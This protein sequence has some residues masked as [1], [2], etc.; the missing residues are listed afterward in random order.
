MK[1][2][3]GKKV[4][5]LIEGA[6]SLEATVVSDSKNIVF[7]RIGDDEHVTRIV[8]NKIS[9]FKPLDLEDEK[10]PTLLMLFCENPTINCPGVKFIKKGDGFSQSDFDTFM[11][12]CK[13]RC[14]SCRRGSHGDIRC[15]DGKIMTNIFSGCLFGKYPEEK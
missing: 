13:S 1:E 15:V 8:K 7:V 5:F 2:F 4:R 6:G 3:V 14:E 9:L 11:G 10:V 12:P